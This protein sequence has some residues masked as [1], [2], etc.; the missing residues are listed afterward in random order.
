MKRLGAKIHR[1]QRLRRVCSNAE[2][3]K[4]LKKSNR[5]ENN[6]DE[7]GIPRSPVRDFHIEEEQ[8]KQD[9]QQVEE[10]VIRHPCSND[11]QPAGRKEKER[12]DQFNEKNTKYGSL[13]KD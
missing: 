7:S 13:L 6:G 11:S 12:R 5:D 3:R 4:K 9:R 1:P 2:H 8:A 10:R